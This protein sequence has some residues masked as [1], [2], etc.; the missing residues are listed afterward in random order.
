MMSKIRITKEFHFEM[1]HALL[2]YD[3]LCSSI[4]GH[5]YSLSVTLIGEP[6]KNITNSKNGM[7][8]DFTLLKSIVKE[9][10][11]DKLDHAF[12]LNSETPDKETLIAKN[13]FDKVIFTNFQPTCENLLIDFASVLKD[14]FPPN[15]NLYSL[16]LRETSTSFAEWY[17]E[18]NI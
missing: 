6:I 4:H 7:V 17:A 14:K 18:D 9:N 2:N 12:L 3:G 10:I 16:K 13:L 11:V 15:L 8:I 1:A 5:S